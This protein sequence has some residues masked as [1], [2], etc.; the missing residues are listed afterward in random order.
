[1]TSFPNSPRLL[2]GGLVLIDPST[3]RVVR[4]ISLQYNP[5]S[6]SRT[7]QAQGS[8][9]SG[10]RSDVL[11]LKDPAVETINLDAEIDAADQVEKGD[12]TTAD[13][14]MHPK[15]AVLDTLVHPASSQLQMNES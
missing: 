14:G 6:V 15:M 13:R 7:L 8:G 11:R 5:D 4:I 3:S 10:D 12:E 1:M 9:E 2:K